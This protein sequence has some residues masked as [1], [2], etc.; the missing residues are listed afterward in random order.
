MIIP[1]GRMTLP[2]QLYQELSVAQ[3]STDHWF[4]A[5]RCWVWLM[6]FGKVTH[7]PN[8]G[9][10]VLTSGIITIAIESWSLALTFA[11]WE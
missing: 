2:T 3:V 5:S 6:P 9:L 7:G 8:T 1:L 4:L 11:I 10:D